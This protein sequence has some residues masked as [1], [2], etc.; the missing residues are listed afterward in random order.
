M[1]W[2]RRGADRV[3]R[4]TRD[5]PG[6]LAR[7]Y[8]V[9]DEGLE[10]AEK[11]PRGIAIARRIFLRGT[12]QRAQFAQDQV[13]ARRFVAAQQPTLELCN[14]ERARL[15]LEAAQRISQLIDGGGAVRH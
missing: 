2:L 13:G 10:P 4:A 7:Q 9:D 1:P 5:A 3:E 15:R 8:I 12:E 6:M 14:E 11:H